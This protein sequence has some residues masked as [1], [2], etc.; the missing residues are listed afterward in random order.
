MKI[1]KQLLITGIVQ[2]VGFRPFVYNLAKRL[3]LSGKVYNSEQGVVIEAQGSK[4][5]IEI[6]VLLLQKNAPKLS[7][8]EAVKIK[9]TKVKKEN[10][11]AI[12]PSKGVKTKTTIPADIALCPSCARDIAAKDNRRYQYPFTNCTQCGPRYTI[13]KSLPYDRAKTTMRPFKMCKACRQEYENPT[14]RRFH[15]E[16]NCCP[17][18]GPKVNFVYQ[19]K[20]AGGIK[21]AAAALKSGKI[22]AIK[23]IGGFHLACD[24]LNKKTVALLRKRKNIPLI[25][26]GLATIGVMLPYTPLHKIIFD[27]LGP[28]PLV[29]TSGNISGE[30]ICID[31]EEAKQKLANIADG[32][33]LHSRAIYSRIDDSVL[34]ELNGKTY[35]LRRARGYTPSAITLPSKLKR[36]TLALGGNLTNSFCLAKDN[37]IYPSQ[38]IGDLDLPANINYFKQAASQMQ[39]LLNIKP[40]VFLRDKHP[41]YFGAHFKPKAKQVQHHLAHALSVALEHNLPPKAL[42]F[43]FDGTGYGEDKTIWGA[44]FLLINKNNWQRL[45]YIK[46]IK[47]FGGESATIDIWKC[48]LSYM[49]A[50]GL[51]RQ[52]IKKILNKIPTKTLDLA[53]KSLNAGL[54]SYTASSAGRLF[55]A[56]SAMLGICLKT[57]YQAQGAMELEAAANGAKTQAAYPFTVE[58]KKGFTTIDTKPLIAALSEERQNTALAA[59][60][61]HNTLA[62]MICQCAALLSAQ[63]GVKT[64]LLSGGV[65]QNKK[66]LSSCLKG[67]EAKGLK[68]YANNTLPIGD[69]NVA[70][71][72]IY[73]SYKNFV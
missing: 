66:L 67:L 69:G 21:E 48:A 36:H 63:T 4:E 11:F 19:N 31:N 16:P 1:R 8:I 15:A 71:G 59:A 47:I 44:E 57:T 61:F 22:I 9:S 50:S 32:F 33:L 7:K 35:F 68:V 17:V 41:A 58:T 27:I 62:K 60:K 65:F 6:F 39:K 42:A 46:P 40:Q 70:A 73:A 51:I 3:N 45:G 23:S 54:N 53:L 12:I 10:T 13:I 20:Q 24:A 52:K 25:S 14:N 55:D 2:A 64:I 28:N 38:Y 26:D 56:V 49:A 18:C 5:N 37:K 29:M 34:F 72:Q 30:P 43:V